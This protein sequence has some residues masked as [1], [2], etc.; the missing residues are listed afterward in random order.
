MS[1]PSGWYASMGSGTDQVSSLATNET[2]SCG[3]PGYM[4][5]KMDCLSV[6][7]GHSESAVPRRYSVICFFVTAGDGVRYCVNF[8]ADADEQR[9]I[10]I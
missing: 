5:G 7:S 10:F 6:P 2:P 4:H 1:S 8:L 3:C 9:G